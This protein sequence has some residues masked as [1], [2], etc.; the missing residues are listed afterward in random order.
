MDHVFGVGKYNACF[1]RARMDKGTK[2]RIAVGRKG[3]NK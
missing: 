1:P 2:V 3:L